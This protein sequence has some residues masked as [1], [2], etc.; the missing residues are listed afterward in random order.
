MFILLTLF[1][2]LAHANSAS[3]IDQLYAELMSTPPRA[4]VG[5][6]DEAARFAAKLREFLRLRALS[7]SPIEI[8]TLLGAMAKFAE[9]GPEMNHIFALLADP[10]NGLNAGEVAALMMSGHFTEYAG[11]TLHAPISP[12]QAFQRALGVSAVAVTEVNKRQFDIF[13]ALA[14]HVVDLERWSELAL[15]AEDWDAR[16]PLVSRALVSDQLGKIQDWQLKPTQWAKVLAFYRPEF[17][18]DAECA[19]IVANFTLI[20]DVLTAVAAVPEAQT[21][22]CLQ[23]AA[24]R[25]WRKPTQGLV[26]TL[27]SPLGR[28]SSA[29]YE[30][31]LAR[32]KEHYLRGAWRTDCGDLLAAAVNDDPRLPPRP[33]ERPLARPAYLRV[34]EGGVKSSR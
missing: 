31:S 9:V 13:A 11:T 21:R 4:T 1:L 15:F 7:P 6:A 32:L 16:G 2:G 20:H 19:E 34:I 8:R 10:D 22:L 5:R 17:I 27:L 26:R 3:N 14:D 29:Q 12:G 18:D 24:V 23:H 25:G 30:M 28:N 33:T